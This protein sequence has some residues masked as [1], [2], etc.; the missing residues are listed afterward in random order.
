MAA[1]SHKVFFKF[2]HNPPMPFVTAVSKICLQSWWDLGEEE[3]L[4]PDTVIHL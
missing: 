1:E 4:P 3:V 2:V